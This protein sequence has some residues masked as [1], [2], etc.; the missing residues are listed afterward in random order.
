[1]LAMYHTGQR[2]QATTEP[3]RF[4]FRSAWRV[5]RALCS[6]NIAGHSMLNQSW[7]ECHEFAEDLHEGPVDERSNP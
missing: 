2:D 7:E 1:M 3:K 6:I 4:A 5:D